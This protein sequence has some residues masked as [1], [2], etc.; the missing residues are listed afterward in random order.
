M[1]GSLARAPRCDGQLGHAEAQDEPLA[2]ALGGD[3]RA[4]G[5]R[6]LGDRAGRGLGRGELGL[7]DEREGAEGARRAA[8][9][10][11]VVAGRRRGWSAWAGAPAGAAARRRRPS[12]RPAWVDHPPAAGE[13][14]LAAQRV[15]AEGGDAA[16]AAHVAAQALLQGA[17]QPARVGG[18]DDAAVVLQP[19]AAVGGERH[20]GRDVVAVARAVQPRQ[21]R[22]VAGG[23]VRGQ[24]VARVDA[25][26]LG[27]DAVVEQVRQAVAVVVERVAPL[28]GH[29]RQDDEDAVALGALDREGHRGGVRRRA[30]LHE[31][32]ARLAPGSVQAHARRGLAAAGGRGARADA[33]H[34]PGPRLAPR[35]DEELDR[36]ARRR[37]HVG[38]AHAEVA[39]RDA[40]VPGQLG[41]VARGGQAAA[42]QRRRQAAVARLVAGL[43]RD[44]VGP[45]GDA[46]ARSASCRSTSTPSRRRRSESSSS[47]RRVGP[48]PGLEQPDHG[49]AARAPRDARRRR[50]RWA[51]ARAR[52]RGSGRSR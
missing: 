6:V 9:E 26:Q 49:L 31:V 21:Q 10:V 2:L 14:D 11:D 40:A 52:T 5:L 36:V 43:D 8:E 25:E 15:D 19:R 50:R 13:R 48:G 39:D 33:A 3:D 38:R 7:L 46:G 37:G 22:R 51:G 12:S 1:F 17:R 24:P 42:I 16:A 41:A 27:S 34:R 30:H 23:E 18:E 35:V 29:D 20:V 4:P 45:R 32:D 47:T 28:P 44:Q